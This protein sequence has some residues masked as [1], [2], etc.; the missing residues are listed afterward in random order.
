[1]Q[2]Q[3]IAFV[4]SFGGTNWNTDA[5]V[6]ESLAVRRRDGSPYHRESLARARRAIARRGFMESRR[7]FPGQRPHPSARWPSSHG[8]TA[9]QIGWKV[10]GLKNPKTRAEVRRLRRV[11]ELA[12]RHA[13]AVALQPRLP[14]PKLDPELAHVIEEAREAFDRLERARDHE[15]DARTLRA[16]AARGPPEH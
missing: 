8:T 2:A 7:I 14:T 12:P 9:K 4:A 13:A 5:Q 1:M 11:Q 3:W 6:R 16:L 10:L 15:R